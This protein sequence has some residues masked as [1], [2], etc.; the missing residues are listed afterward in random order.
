MLYER[1]PE[2]MGPMFEQYMRNALM[3][4]AQ[5]SR[6]PGTMAEVV[7]F[8]EDLNFRRA[9]LCHLHEPRVLSCFSPA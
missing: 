9:V 6:G 5:N 2:S 4:L 1:I 8:F 7:P 3:V